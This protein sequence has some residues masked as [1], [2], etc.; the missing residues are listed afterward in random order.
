MAKSKYA[1]WYAD[2]R[3]RK[4]RADHLAKEPLC[5]YCAE[6]GKVTPADVVDHIIPHRGD[7]K[8]FYYGAVQ[9]LCHTCHSSR[10]QRE[11]IGQ[12]SRVERRAQPGSHWAR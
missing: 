5:R 1:N 12:L 7:R 9:S 2:R 3:W 10:K 11:E 4:R 6:E 8:A